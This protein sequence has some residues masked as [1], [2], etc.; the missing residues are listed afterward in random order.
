[1]SGE[2]HTYP[3]SINPTDSLQLFQYALRLLASHITPSIEPDELHLVDL[4]KRHLDKVLPVK[5]LEHN[6]LLGAAGQPTLH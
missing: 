3:K 1:M 5:F 4:I 6:F 2:K